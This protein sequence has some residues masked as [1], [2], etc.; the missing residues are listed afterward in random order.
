MNKSLTNL[1]GID[2]NN[3]QKTL[4]ETPFVNSKREMT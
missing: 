3:R 2:D 4:G 1:D